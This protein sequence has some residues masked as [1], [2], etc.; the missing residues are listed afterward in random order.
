M[1][2]EFTDEAALYDAM[3]TM[4]AWGIRVVDP[5]TW[6]VGAHGDAIRAAAARND[7]DGLLNPGKLNRTALAGSASGA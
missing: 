1:I 3:D 4:R 5:H 2:S 7:P 6:M